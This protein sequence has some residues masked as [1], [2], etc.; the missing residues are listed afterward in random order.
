VR[1]AAQ[2]KVT[3]LFGGRIGWVSEELTAALSKS[4]GGALLGPQRKTWNAKGRREQSREVRN[5]GG[6]D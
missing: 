4:T 2:S 6:G 3:L 5:V 1:D